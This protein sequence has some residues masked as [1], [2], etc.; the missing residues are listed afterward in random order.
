MLRV[1]PIRRIG[2]SRLWTVAMVG[3]V[4]L[5]LVACNTSKPP[6]PAEAGPKTFAIPS[7]AGAAVVAATKSGD[8]A[9]LLAIFGPD[10]ADLIF[11]GDAAQDKQTGEHFTTAY[12]AMN[13]WRKQTD[14]SQTLIVGA[15]N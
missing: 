11:S 6:A 2:T 13:R 4:F 5:S 9:A 7:D 15:D 10:S 3:G 1:A 8:R 14:G 12:E